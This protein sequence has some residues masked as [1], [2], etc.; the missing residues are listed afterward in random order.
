ML[1]LA[2]KPHKYP[3]ALLQAVCIALGAYI[4]I[5]SLLLI[6]YG[7]FLYSN[8]GALPEYGLNNLPLWASIFSL[9]DSPHVIT[10]GLIVLA[11]LGFALCIGVQSPLIPL[12]AW[13]LY[14]SFQ[15]RNVLTEHPGTDV[16]GLVLL[17]VTLA[18]FIKKYYS[19]NQNLPSQVLMLPALLYEGMWIVVGLAF[20][21]S[22]VAR[23]RGESW[24]GGTGIA[25]MFSIMP[26][27]HNPVSEFLQREIIALPHAIISLLTYSAELIFIFALP[28]AL[29]KQTR[30]FLL[31]ALTF[32]YFI[33]LI[34]SDMS[35]IILA[36]FILF[37]LLADVLLPYER[38]LPRSIRT[39]IS[40]IVRYRFF[41]NQK[42]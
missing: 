7:T 18:F 38:Y 26:I 6:P 30:S 20:T 17:F 13:V 33:V 9:F 16:I 12:F 22:G 4:G 39:S 35:Q 28:L 15:N 32:M 31:L 23:I 27:R 1:S 21:A 5:Y 8:Q 11:L 14:V 41:W 2:Q 37:L 24:I 25:E 10:G 29:F 19:P 40:R 36:L 42:L 34:I 3:L